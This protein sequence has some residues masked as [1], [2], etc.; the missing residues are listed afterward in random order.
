MTSRS[1][2]VKWPTTKM[3][4]VSA[5]ERIGD[6]NDEKSTATAV[7]TATSPNTSRMARSTVPLSLSPPKTVMAS[8]STKKSVTAMIATSTA[9]RQQH[10]EVLA[11]HELLAVDGLR[12][13]RE[14]GLAIELLVDEVDADEDG[15]E[16]AD[17]LDAD[18]ARR[19]G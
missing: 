12:D 8:P 14:D 13:E 16:R 2:G 10:A 15:D 9:K 7:M 5:P 11:E 3:P 4:S 18:Q 19:R 6:E 17:Q 1:S